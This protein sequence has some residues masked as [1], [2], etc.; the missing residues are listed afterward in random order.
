MKE[1]YACYRKL[2]LKDPHAAVD[3]S[4]NQHIEGAP[5]A[6]IEF[7]SGDSHIIQLQLS[8]SLAPNISPF[9]MRMYESEDRVQR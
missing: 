9:N 3:S 4:I 5:I 6:F 2:P 1:L 8:E 7:D